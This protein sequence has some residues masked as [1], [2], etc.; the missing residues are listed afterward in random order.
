MKVTQT[1]QPRKY[2]DCTGQKQITQ[3]SWH[4]YGGGQ[5]IFPEKG[6]SASHQSCCVWK[7]LH[8]PCSLPSELLRSDDLTRAP[9]LPSLTWLSHKQFTDCSMN[10]IHG[11]ISEEMLNLVWSPASAPHGGDLGSLGYLPPCLSQAVSLGV[12][13]FSLCLTSG[14]RG[15]PQASPSPLHTAHF[16]MLFPPGH[17]WF[18]YG[19]L[20]SCLCFSNT[21]NEFQGQSTCWWYKF[22]SGI[23]VHL[24]SYR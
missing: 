4:L 2:R 7:I 3:K 22:I 12:R 23:A 8:E 16:R 17:Y 20:D 14:S 19:G 24:S 21:Q 13:V 5:R 18:L 10:A 9:S 1:P 11:K 6:A 15:L